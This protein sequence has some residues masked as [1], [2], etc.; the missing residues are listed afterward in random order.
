MQ[1]IS[2]A[3]VA[4]SL[5]AIAEVDKSDSKMQMDHLAQH[6]NRHQRRAVAKLQRKVNSIDNKIDKLTRQLPTK[7]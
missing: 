2:R 5:E 6:G 3:I 7:S 4:G 1:E